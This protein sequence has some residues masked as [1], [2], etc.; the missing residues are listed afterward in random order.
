MMGKELG[1][2]TLGSPERGQGMS[3]RRGCCTG[4]GLAILSA[5]CIIKKSLRQR[6]GRAECKHTQDGRGHCHYA[7]PP[8]A[9]PRK[10][11]TC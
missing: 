8:A 2:P 1:T 9:S 6:A 7:P 5:G 10:N 11:P 3:Y 4:G